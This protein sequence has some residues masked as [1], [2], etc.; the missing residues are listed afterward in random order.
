MTSYT[1]QPTDTGG[2]T[3]THPENELTL[4]IP[5]NNGGFPVK[6]Q[7]AMMLSENDVITVVPG[8]AAVSII[9]NTT[10]TGRQ[11]ALIQNENG[12]NVWRVTAFNEEIRPKINEQTLSENKVLQT[13]DPVWQF[14]TPT[15]NNVSVILSSAI[16]DEYI[17]VNGSST[18][19]L[20]IKE[21]LSGSSILELTPQNRLA[22]LKRGQTQWKVLNFHG[23]L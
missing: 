8:T 14:L 11:I 12:E 2:L 5:V 1:L 6:W 18:Y 9:G 13:G 23:S 20:F 15:T 10:L 3:L 4:I 17:I 7:T 16:A 21:I 19:S 22:W